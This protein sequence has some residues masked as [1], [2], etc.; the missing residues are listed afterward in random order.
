[1]RAILRKPACWVFLI[2]LLSNA[3]FWHSRDWNTAS[4]LMLVYSLVDR[5]TV[6]ITGLEGQ[7]GDRARFE[8]QYYS[9][10]PPGFPLLAALPYVVAKL[11]L[12][13][14][15]HPLGG[16][17]LS[18][19]AA[20]YW[21]TLFTSGV[22]T[23]LT[24]ALLV[25]WSRCLGCGPG[26]AALLGLAYGLATPAYVYAT[27]ASGH[28]PTAF[29]LFTSFYLLWQDAPRWR[30]ARSFFAG[31]LAAYAVVIELQVAPVSV[32]LGCYLL[33]RCV[34][35][36]RSGSDLAAFGIGGAIPT[37][38]LL[39]YDQLAFGSP[40][41]MGYFHHATPEF[42]AV[43]SAQHPLGLAFP[44]S[45]WGRT[46]SLLWG[47]HRG[48]AFY[49]PIVFLTIPGWAALWARRCYSVAAVTVLV[50]AAVLLVNIC[51]PEWTGGWSTGP[52]LLVP[53]LPFAVLPIAGL[54]A[55]ES[56]L[57]KIATWVA[58][59]LALA[60]GVEMF[61]FQGADGR[62]PQDVA[63]PITHGVW[64]LWSGE[65]L[66]WWRFNERFSRNIT[67]AALPQW[68]ASLPP[69]WQWIQFV[70]LPVFQ[71]AAIFA[72]WRFGLDGQRGAVGSHT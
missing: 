8:G 7:T 12:G 45:F 39:G 59:V 36:R 21:V 27:L 38:I 44:E 68:V 23:A 20:D 34:R 25:Y 29:A 65:P 58:L 46:L 1:L 32:I 15:S 56:A 69:A 2:L 54:L 72:L 17:A 41:E 33:V 11:L 47:R 62:I 42:A 14:P 10:K 16:L 61:L 24:G 18:F 53:L 43:H 4:R 5:G 63:D 40:W 52:R 37:L 30:R 9:D 55:G 60:G 57:A 48:L 28:Q 3:F 64:P 49:A 6:T 71:A 22:L 26:R 67:V 19:W 66:P 50:V 35:G 13:I 70:P 51:Y 31:F